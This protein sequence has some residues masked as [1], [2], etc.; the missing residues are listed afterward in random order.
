MGTECLVLRG[1]NPE[2]FY[3][4]IVDTQLGKLAGLNKGNTPFPSLV[5]SSHSLKGIDESSG[6]AN[7]D[8]VVMLIPLRLKRDFHEFM[9]EL[10]RTIKIGDPSTVFADQP[11]S[12]WAWLADYL[13]LKPSFFGLG[14]NLNPIFSKIVGAKA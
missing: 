2:A 1:A 3:N 5:L 6:I 13:E 8:I 9:R 4:R 14:V 12:K 11:E 10:A 7:E